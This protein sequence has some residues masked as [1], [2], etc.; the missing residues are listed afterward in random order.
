[1]PAA[2]G[3]L[4]QIN[5]LGLAAI[6]LSHFVRPALFDSMTAPA[7]PDNTRRHVY[8]DGA[9]ETAIGLC[10]IVPKTRKFALAGLIGYGAFLG[11]NVARNRG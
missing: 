8:I 10:L 9:V 2:T 5:G 7:F 11:L 3:R 1:M 4:A 6:G